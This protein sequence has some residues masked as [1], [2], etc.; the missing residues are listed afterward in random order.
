MNRKRRGEED[1]IPHVARMSEAATNLVQDMKKDSQNK[2]MEEVDERVKKIVSQELRETQKL[3]AQQS[4]M[5]KAIYSLICAMKEY[6]TSVKSAV[7]CTFV[8]SE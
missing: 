5:I 1:L 4:A 2:I 6:E 8:N 7:G 3:L